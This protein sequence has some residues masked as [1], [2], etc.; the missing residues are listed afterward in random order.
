ML[1]RRHL[2]M[3]VRGRMFRLNTVMPR[4]GG[5]RPQQLH[6]ARGGIAKRQGSARREYAK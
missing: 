2:V 5:G 1:I 3:P 6:V 4:C